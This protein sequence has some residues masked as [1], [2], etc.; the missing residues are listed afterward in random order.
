MWNYFQNY[1][2]E[3]NLNYKD[4]VVIFASNSFLR[5]YTLNLKAKWI[6]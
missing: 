3:L 6:I 4:A 5:F 1:E 2:V